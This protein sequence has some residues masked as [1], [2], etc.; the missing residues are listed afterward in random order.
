M[1]NRVD[2][3]TDQGALFKRTKVSTTARVRLTLVDTV[4]VEM[5]RSTGFTHQPDVISLLVW[6]RVSGG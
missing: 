1:E 6:M 3:S 5:E 4:D 2:V